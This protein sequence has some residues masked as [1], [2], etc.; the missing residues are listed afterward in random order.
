[1]ADLWE[2]EV[3][4]PLMQSHVNMVQIITISE[5]LMRDHFPEVDLL[6]SRPDLREWSNRLVQHPSVKATM[7]VSN[8]QV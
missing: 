5:V 3:G 6:S 8:A 4:H 2:T 7:L 1:M